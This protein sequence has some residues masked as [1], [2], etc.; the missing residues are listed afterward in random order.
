MTF[1]TTENTA[2]GKHNIGVT[3]TVLAPDKSIAIASLTYPVM[4]VASEED[5]P[6]TNAGTMSATTKL[7]N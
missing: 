7:K 3:C 4:V 2:L 6:S 1:P 5:L